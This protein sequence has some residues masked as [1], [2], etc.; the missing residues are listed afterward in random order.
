MGNAYVACVITLI[1]VSVVS[2]SWLRR[3]RGS[4]E[5]FESCV[6]ATAGCVQRFTQHRWGMV[7]TK[8]D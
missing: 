6:I 8:P 3:S 2:Q 4:L 1:A 5:F 7:L